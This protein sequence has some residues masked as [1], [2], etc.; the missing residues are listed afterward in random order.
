MSRLS[1]GILRHRRT[2]QLDEWARKH[3]QA[4]ASSL[5][6][7]GVRIIARGAGRHATSRTPAWAAD[8]P[9]PRCGECHWLRRA[10]D[11]LIDRSPLAAWVAREQACARPTVMTA[12]A[13]MTPN[14]RPG[15]AQG[16]ESY[17]TGLKHVDHLRRVGAQPARPDPSWPLN[18]CRGRAG[19]CAGGAA[20][21]GGI[22]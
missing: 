8:L 5:T 14:R 16:H 17:H 2:R 10:L 19:G 21:R 18:R 22:A 1:G 20:S 7:R 13:V 15:G 3:L 12:R 11:G 4:A 6:R 9:A